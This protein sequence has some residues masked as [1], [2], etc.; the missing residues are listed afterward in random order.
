VRCRTPQN[1]DNTNIRVI[2]VYP[3]E[4][5][6]SSRRWVIF[7]PFCIACGMSK[8]RIG[9]VST[10][11]GPLQYILCSTSSRNPGLVG[12]MLAMQVSFR[13]GH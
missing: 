3:E 2:W 8:S 9:P 1:E 4:I 6:K 11:G 13:P 7:D 12:I 10:D 5:V